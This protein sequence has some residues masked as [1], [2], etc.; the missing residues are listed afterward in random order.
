M[1]VILF[2]AHPNLL[3]LG[4]M[5]FPFVLWYKYQS[6]PSGM[7][8]VVIDRENNISRLL[9]PGRRL[10]LPFVESILDIRGE[11]LFPITQK[12]ITFDE[13][14]Y[15]LF[16]VEI[17]LTLKINNLIQ[18]C[19]ER[20]KQDHPDFPFIIPYE[21]PELF[22]EEM[23][24][25]GGKHFIQLALKKTIDEMKLNDVTFD[26]DITIRECLNRNLLSLQESW[27]KLHS[28]PLSS[29]SNKRSSTYN[30]LHIPTFEICHIYPDGGGQRKQVT[31]VTQQLTAMRCLFSYAKKIEEDLELKP[32]T[33]KIAKIIIDNLSIR[34]LKLQDALRLREV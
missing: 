17:L 5:I 3:F 10:A 13:R 29:T 21:T 9:Y 16:K 11:R 20:L 28:E 8:G 32:S 34:N 23:M 19:T 27:N 2:Y 18:L 25:E 33:V 26:D 1:G 6:I 12:R 14:V 22:I 31:D 4:V 15:N 7:V 24:K 30:W